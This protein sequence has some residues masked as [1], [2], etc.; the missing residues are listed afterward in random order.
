MTKFKVGDPVRCIYNDKGTQEYVGSEGKI[1]AVGSGQHPYCVSFSDAGFAECELQ[2]ITNKMSLIEKAG[3][4]FKS[5]PE[6]SL[7]K[8]GFFNKED[9]ATPEGQQV[10]ISYLMKKDEA[11][12]KDVVD[13]ILAE[14]AK[15]AG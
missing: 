11:F 3:L 7:R 2:L 5:E 4:L 9:L 10:Y 12:K 13:P 8:A 14:D 15:N 6:K 1:T